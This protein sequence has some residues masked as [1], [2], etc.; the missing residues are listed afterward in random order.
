[1]HREH[2]VNFSRD[3]QILGMVV[4][5]WARR[6]ESIDRNKAVV[7]ANGAKR[8]SFVLRAECGSPAAGGY[9]V[10]TSLELELEPAGH[11]AELA[12]A[13]EGA[14]VRVLD[15]L[16]G[17]TAVQFVGGR[18]QLEKLGPLAEPPLMK[19]LRSL[20]DGPPKP[21]RGS[22]AP[23]SERSPNACRRSTRPSCRPAT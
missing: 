7:N 17:N 12:S 14:Y 1:M 23:A 6:E 13:L 5:R 18:L 19:E 22:S 11:L 3:A 16:G 4:K 9:A 2:G 8:G 21:T 10:L 15:G 20:I